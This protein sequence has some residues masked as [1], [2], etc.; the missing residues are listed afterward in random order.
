MNRTVNINLAGL[1]FH[2][3]EEAYGVLANY[4]A[5]LRAH[6]QGTEG[7]DEIIADIEGRLAE[8]FRDRMGKLRDVVGLDDVQH[9]INLLGR[10]ESFTDDEGSNG[11]TSTSTKAD[12]E[13]NRGPKRLFRDPDDKVVG[14]VCSGISHYFGISDPVWLRAALAISMFVFGSGFILYFILWAIIPKAR[15]TTEK[16]QMRGENVTVSNIEKRISEEFNELKDRVG[17][18]TGNKAGVQKVGGV[19]ERLVAMLVSLFGMAVK[20]AGAVLGFFLLMGGIFWFIG[21]MM[22]AFFIPDFMSIDYNGTVSRV[23]IDSLVGQLF[24]SAAH[25]LIFRIGTLLA[26]GIPGLMVAFFGSRLLIGYRLQNRF[27]VLPSLALWISGIIMQVYGGVSAFNMFK[28]SYTGTQ[29]VML[30]QT[31]S[32]RTLYLDLDTD[33][34]SIRGTEFDEFMFDLLISDDGERLFGKPTLNVVKSKDDKARI[35]IKRIAR[36]ADRKQATELAN[37]INYSLEMTDSVVR[38]SPWFMFPEG[39][40]WRAQRV[41]IEVQVPEG[42]TVYLSEE[43]EKIIYDIQNVNGTYDGDMG[44]RRWKMHPYGLECV[45]C[46]GLKESRH[47]SSTSWDDEEGIEEES[48]DEDIQNAR[49]AERAIEKVQNKMERIRR[50]IEED[51]LKMEERMRQK[52]EELRKMEQD[53]NKGKSGKNKTDEQADASPNRILLRRQV[54]VSYPSTNETHRTLTFT[55]GPAHS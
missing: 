1:V 3:D 7:Q 4:I 34:T 39:Q 54:T 55:Y 47:T 28:D 52:E 48:S 15:T 36:G 17:T 10:P 44:G 29:E 32:T 11:A 23:M 53:L 19:L 42:T 24:P 38:F 25:A 30:N 12:N 49:K 22:T 13:P 5:D 16:L 2:I 14:G 43:L 6:F 37:A 45:D 9:A 50:E 20:F 33:T 18:M 26:W 40:P 8:I 35:I 27:V 51:R 31:D 41:R 21:V 46:G